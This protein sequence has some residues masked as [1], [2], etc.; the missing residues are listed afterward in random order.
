MFRQQFFLFFFKFWRTHILFVGPLIPL[1]W[2][3]GGGFQSQGGYCLHAFLPVHHSQI[4]LWCNTCQPL[5]GQHGNPSCSLHASF[6]R[7]RMPGFER[8]ICHSEHRHS[9]HS[10]T[11]PGLFRPQFNNYY[12]VVSVDIQGCHTQFVLRPYLIHFSSQSSENHQALF[13]YPLLFF[14]HCW[15]VRG[16][17]FSILV[18]W[19]SSALGHWLWLS[20]VKTLIRYVWTVIWSEQ[21]LRGSSVTRTL[22]W[23]CL[24]QWTLINQ[25]KHF[26]IYCRFSQ[27]STR[28]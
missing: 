16:D 19:G 4:H 8:G 15:K 6:S 25:H 5:E 1:F 3:S 17:I 28:L 23:T 12:F 10:A 11:A 26:V 9:S 13:Y 7:G 18:V 22:V 24:V 20:M 21:R 14:W 2:T 27:I